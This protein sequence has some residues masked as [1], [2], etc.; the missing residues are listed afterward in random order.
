M[1]TKKIIIFFILVFVVQSLIMLPANAKTFVIA[2]AECVYEIQINIV[3]DFM[4][5]PA[6]EQADFLLAKWQQGMEQVWNNSNAQNFATGCAAQYI[7]DLQIMSKGKSCLDYP[8]YHC[9][10][11]VSDETNK[12]GYIADASLAIANSQ[13]NS[14]GQWT[15]SASGF[16]AAH[17]VGH[18]MGLGEDYHY[19]MVNGQNK[20]VNDNYKTIGV[21]SIMAQTWGRVSAFPEHSKQIINQAGFAINPLIINLDQQIQ[22]LNKAE[23]YS[24][25][26]GPKVYTDRILPQELAGK[27]I[28]GE[29][30][31]AVYLVDQAGKLRWV[32]SEK[33]AQDLFGLNWAK[34]IIWFSDSII[35]TYQ[36]ADPV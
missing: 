8:E 22:S 36:F 25:P 10:E 1:L 19:E 12:R 15:S 14:Y 17:E 30:D 13:Q 33:T 9:I 34:N 3:F 24:S 6:Q 2:K 21:Q 28:K 29:S 35:F 32:S 7:F 23:Y 18:M 5:Q 4:D 31:S 20:W 26:L 16:N 27:L 11:V